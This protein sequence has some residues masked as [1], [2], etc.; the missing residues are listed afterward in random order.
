MIILLH[1][2][3]RS[4]KDVCRRQAR[5][6]LPRGFAPVR[7]LL[8]P[9]E[10]RLVP[11]S[12]PILTGPDLTVTDL[13]SQLVAS[14]LVSQ[15]LGQGVAV[16]NVQFRGTTTSAGE[17]T[18]DAGI[19]GFNF[20][21]VLSTGNV[22]NLIGPNTSSGASQSNGLSGDENLAFLSG[23]TTF[24]A[25]VLE[26]DFVP[27]FDTVSFQY[28]FASEEY[29]EYVSSQYNDVF[30]FFVNGAN[31]AMLP[32]GTP[33]SIH[34]VNN[35]PQNPNSQ[36]YIN[37][38]QASGAPLNTQMD[39]LTTVLTAVATVKPGQV[40][41][42]KLAIA[43]VGD[44]AFDSN[45]LIRANSFTAATV[46]DVTAA[47]NQLATEK[48]PATISLGSFSDEEG[49]PWNVSVDWG[50]GS[51]SNFTVTEAG[52]LGTLSHTFA[53]PGTQNVTVTVTDSNE[54]SSSASFSVA[55]AD[56]PVDATGGF[57][58][59][60]TEQR[61]SDTQTVATFT[62][63]GGAEPG[64]YSATI[65]WGDD[66]TSPGTISEPVSGVFTV[67]GSHRYASFGPYI[68]TT[69]IGHND[70]ATQ[71]A[72]SA[73]LVADVR[74]VV[75]PIEI[76]GTKLRLSDDGR[77]VSIPQNGVIAGTGAFSDP[78][79]NIWSATVYFGDGSDPVDVPLLS[80]KTFVLPEHTYTKVGDF[81]VKV[82]V[83]DG[84]H[85]PGFATFVVNVLKPKEFD[86]IGHTKILNLSAG[87]DISSE[88][89]SGSK[90]E[91]HAHWPDGSIV[92]DATVSV[93]NYLQNP[94]NDGSNGDS[95]DN[96]I[97]VTKAQGS[98]TA[99]PVAFFDVRATNFASI[100]GASLTVTYWYTID[101]NATDDVTLYFWDG[102][103]WSKVLDGVDQDGDGV[104]DAPLKITLL[105]PD[106]TVA[107]TTDGKVTRGIIVTY[108]ETLS[109]PHLSQLTG[110]VF[111]V[112][113]P[114]PTTSP[115][116]TISNPLSFA[117]NNSQGAFASGQFGQTISF[118]SNSTTTLTLR[119]SQDVQTSASRSRLANDAGEEAEVPLPE[120]REEL[121]TGA[122][123]RWLA[124]WIQQLWPFQATSGL[125]D[126]V[127]V[128]ARAEAQQEMAPD[129]GNDADVPPPQEM[130]P[131]TRSE[132][133]DAIFAPFL[134]QTAAAGWLLD[135][136]ADAASHRLEAMWLPAAALVGF[137]QRE[138]AAKKSNTP[139]R[140]TLK[141]PV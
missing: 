115:A 21:I 127:K 75:T 126:A 79:K 59:T 94:T 107:H 113:A 63:P 42:I 88:L 41:H 65:D 3:L 120:L 101:E 119:V 84:S 57:L 114:V 69:T 36:Y 12:V 117:S 87:G 10:N 4:V 122:M 129:C 90:V 95:S 27:L 89:P 46:P 35:L 99:T 131:Q 60:A 92:D 140:P 67:T 137:C 11:A 105:N 98:G 100:P 14:D 109:N 123:V 5:C 93:S 70:A 138:A 22:S 1:A 80:D 125:M 49:G 9:L 44:S 50:D 38:D 28:V 91:A 102:A 23:G 32:D 68:I 77:D 16:S 19:F 135:D 106:G 139:R 18:G 52:S 62:D 76:S 33:V 6:R 45:V 112:A 132:A 74:P 133:L 54:L 15:L 136:D 43:D 7:L 134:G 78:G 110:T 128:P 55:V 56:P 130:S 83:D 124:N 96:P 81:V 121:R 2:L 40:N 61:D 85:K 34:T 118:T 108:N 17:F 71:Q 8:E 26:F 66:S 73:A 24:D 51:P 64:S 47:E 72:I 25:T 82:A 30:G 104:G 53:S 86:N 141:T 48:A 116:A 58:V 29:N 103:T 97:N 111:T 20:G 39:G 13:S 37:N 31:V